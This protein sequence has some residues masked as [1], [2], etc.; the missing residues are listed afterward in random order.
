MQQGDT[1]PINGGL[2]SRGNLA[3]ICIEALTNKN[4]KNKTFEVFDDETIKPDAWRKTFAKLIPD[5]QK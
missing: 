3:A 1:V 4:A 2:T 5:L